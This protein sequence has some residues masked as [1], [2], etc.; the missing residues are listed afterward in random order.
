MTFIFKANDM[1]LM[2]IFK[3]KKYLCRPILLRFVHVIKIDYVKVDTIDDIFAK[4]S[5]VHAKVIVRAGCKNC[6]FL[7]AHLQRIVGAAR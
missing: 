5:S 3:I 2:M 7:A 4:C 6:N 1:S